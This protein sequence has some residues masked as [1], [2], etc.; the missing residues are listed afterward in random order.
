MLNKQGKNNMDWNTENSTPLE[1][2]RSAIELIK[3]DTGIRRPMSF[4]EMLYHDSQQLY[5]M[6]YNSEQV[7]YYI[8]F[9]LD[10]YRKECKKNDSN[11]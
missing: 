8:K 7:N 11:N 2:I 4:R 5:L 3:N 10:L 9:F 6:G 1:D